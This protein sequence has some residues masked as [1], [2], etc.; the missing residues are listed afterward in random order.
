MQE[1][2]LASW[3]QSGQKQDHCP[4]L[5]NHNAK[6]KR[7]LPP[8]CDFANGVGQFAARVRTLVAGHTMLERIAQAMLQAREALKVEFGKLHRAMLA[9]VRADTRSGPDRRAWSRSCLCPSVGRS[10]VEDA[11][12][13]DEITALCSI[14]ERTI[15]V[16]PNAK[17]RLAFLERIRFLCCPMS[18]SAGLANR[19]RV[20]DTH[21]D[22]H[23]R[24]PDLDASGVDD[25]GLPRWRAVSPSRLPQSTAANERS[26]PSLTSTHRPSPTHHAGACPCSFGLLRGTYGSF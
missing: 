20:F 21:R 11:M 19:T 2:L 15:R 7:L 13:W 9:I 17:V 3:R 26:I 8:Y 16:D 22:L 23:D 18:I 25:T 10:R 5:L 14:A 4:S 24:P 6:Y 1:N 12:I